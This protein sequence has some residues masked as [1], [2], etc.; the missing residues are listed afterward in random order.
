[1]KRSIKKGFGFGLTSGVITTLGMMVGLNASTHS[2]LAVIGGIIAIAIADAFSDA[3]GIH[4][5][6]ESENKH[7]PR[8]IW[9][10]TFSTFL[11]KFLFALSFVVPVLAFKLYVA[12]GVSVIWGLGLITIFSYH[13]A[14]EQGVKPYKVVLEH[15]GIVVLVIIITHY[16]GKWVGILCC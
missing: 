12:I 3:V 5:S 14:R 2:K 11:F 1:M 7:T 13:M 10:A 4:I 15:V 6:E 16:V 9:E 8:E